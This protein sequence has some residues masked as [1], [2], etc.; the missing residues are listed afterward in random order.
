MQSLMTFRQENPDEQYFAVSLLKIEQQYGVESIQGQCLL[1]LSNE[2]SYSEALLEQGYALIRPEGIK[3]DKVLQQR[4]NKA[5]LR[6]QKKKA[7]IWSDTDARN[8]FR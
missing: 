5:L 2:G 1:H 6:A 3:D 4:F 7:G 8:C